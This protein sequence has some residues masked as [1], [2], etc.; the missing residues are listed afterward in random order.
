METKLIAVINDESEIIVR[1]SKAVEGVGIFDLVNGNEYPAGI[2]EDLTIIGASL[3]SGDSIFAMDGIS[4]LQGAIHN[5]KCVAVV[6]YKSWETD[7]NSDNITSI[8]GVFDNFNDVESYVNK[9]YY[10]IKIVPLNLLN[11]AGW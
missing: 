5:Q 11:S 7:N 10:T 6:V 9:P 2:T 8:E 4:K 1:E 3:D